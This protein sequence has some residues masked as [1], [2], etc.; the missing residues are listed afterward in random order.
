MR[1]YFKSTAWAI[2]CLCSQ[3]SFAQKFME[4]R[5]LDAQSKEPLVGATIVCNHLPQ[6]AITDFSGKFNLDLKSADSVKVSYIGYKSLWVLPS[7]SN[8]IYLSVENTQLNQII[9]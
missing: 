4:G 7:Q 5:V 1:T 6:G 8:T 2:L 3:F 9:I